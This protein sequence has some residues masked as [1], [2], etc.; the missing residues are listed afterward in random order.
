MTSVGLISRPVTQS[1]YGSAETMLLLPMIEGRLLLCATAE[2]VQDWKAMD[3]RVQAHE[4]PHLQRDRLREFCR[5]G[6][7][8]WC[9][10]MRRRGR[11]VR[12]IYEFDELQRFKEHIE[13]EQLSMEVV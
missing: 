10:A 3:R 2:D 11:C 6:Q 9:E 4:P 13:L 12:G 5:D 7:P 1:R 8:L